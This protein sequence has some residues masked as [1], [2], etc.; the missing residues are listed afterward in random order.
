MT[1][2]THSDYFMLALCLWREATIDGAVGMTAVGSVVRNRAIK[3][4]TTFY[5][6]VVR[7]WQFSSISDPKDPQLTKYPSDLDATWKLAQDIATGIILGVI[8][9][10]TNGST[11]YYA[12]RAMTQGNIAATTINLDGVDTVF[13]KGWDRTKVKY[14]TKQGSQYFFTEV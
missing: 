4:G 3:R 6:E 7:K 9:D 8:A 12:P 11:M 5:A 14:Q 10:T 13:P 2:A 1:P